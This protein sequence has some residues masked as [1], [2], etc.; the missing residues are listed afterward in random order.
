MIITRHTHW[1]FDRDDW[2]NA[3]WMSEPEA[4]EFRAAWCRYRS[5]LEANT[6]ADLSPASDTKS[7]LMR[8]HDQTMTALAC[9]AVSRRFSPDMELS[10]LPTIDGKVIASGSIPFSGFNTRTKALAAAKKHITAGQPGDALPVD[11][12]CSLST[13]SLHQSLTSV[14]KKAGT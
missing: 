10:W 7:R 11:E 12:K 9:G 14:I 8:M 6:L 13:A 5:E 2:S 3:I 4:T 1:D